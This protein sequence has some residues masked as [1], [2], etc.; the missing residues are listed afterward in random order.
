MTCKCCIRSVGI[1]LLKTCS[2]LYT[3]CGL[4]LSGPGPT[5]FSCSADRWYIHCRIGRGPAL[6][7][8]GNWLQN[9]IPPGVRTESRSGQIVNS[10]FV[11]DAKSG[12]RRALERAAAHPE[13]DADLEDGTEHK[14][15]DGVDNEAEDGSEAEVVDGAPKTLIRNSW[16]NHIRK[17]STQ[18][19]HSLR[20]SPS[21]I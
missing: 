4:S 6:E 3:S 20:L 21:S 10:R 17:F 14:V 15:E 7:H 12:A 11:E 19:G 1:S 16:V 8:H 18:S 9:H 5:A 2:R 13:L